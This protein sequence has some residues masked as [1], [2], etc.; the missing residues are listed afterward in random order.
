MSPA[1]A[2]HLHPAHQPLTPATTCHPAT[3]TTPTLVYQPATP[4]TPAT[5]S[6]SYQPATPS[7]QP[8]TPA[9]PSAYEDIVENIS[10]PV[11]SRE[12]CKERVSSYTYAKKQDGKVVCN[13]EDC[14][15]D[16][17]Q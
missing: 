17:H 7:Y 13:S 5:P 14:K 12:D 1:P 11:F 3:P 8:Q 6:S 4:Y 9:T 10:I 2:P 15:V 16:F